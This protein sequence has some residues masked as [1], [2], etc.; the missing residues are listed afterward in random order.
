ML[1]ARDITE[2]I[3]VYVRVRRT[4]GNIVLLY[5]YLI[6]IYLT[7]EVKTSS[8]VWVRY[9]VEYSARRHQLIVSARQR[10]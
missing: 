8:S 3:V 2:R 4:T 7:D 1:T 6:A 5:L 10:G 9:M